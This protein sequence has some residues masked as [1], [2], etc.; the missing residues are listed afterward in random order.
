MEDVLWSK[1]KALI[2]EVRPGKP[3]A[4]R[5]RGSDKSVSLSS[6]HRCLSLLKA[7]S[8]ATPPPYP[9]LGM[10]GILVEVSIPLAARSWCQFEAEISMDGLGSPN[11]K[12]LF[13]GFTRGGLQPE[14]LADRLL[15]THALP[16]S[17]KLK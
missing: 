16:A 11:K 7:I 10:V 4:A 13:K 8:A 2:L 17:K 15:E 14:T 1:Q 5:P 6:R 3:G 12:R 9:I